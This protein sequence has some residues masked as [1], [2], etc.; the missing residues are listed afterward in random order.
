M[1]VKSFDNFDPER[2]PVVLGAERALLKIS[3]CPKFSIRGETFGPFKSETVT[4][5]TYA[6]ISILTRGFGEVA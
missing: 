4:V 2:D 6:A 1:R 5:P 3:F